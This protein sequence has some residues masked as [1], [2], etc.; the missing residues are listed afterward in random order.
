M[1]SRQTGIFSRG[2]R[3]LHSAAGWREAFFSLPI[4]LRSLILMMAIAVLWFG[5]ADPLLADD[6]NKEFLVGVDFSK[7]VLTDSSFTKANL[8]GSNF[9]DSD[10]RG[11]SFFGANLEDA[12]LT[13]A[14]LSSATL[15]TARF[16]DA[17]LTNAILEG[18]FAFNAK[19]DGAI[20][21]GADFTDVELRQ[22][23][24][25]YLCKTAKGSNPVTKRETRVT[26]NCR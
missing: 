13:G 12:N 21:D 25:L 4:A 8:R 2:I 1:K 23:A 22:D 19:F 18:A 10:L 6:Y 24:Q 5:T 7:R 15:D 14:N 3:E 26:L 11:V 9:T 16:T 17:N 20:V